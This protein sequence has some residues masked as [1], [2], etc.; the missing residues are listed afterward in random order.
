MTCCMAARMAQY[1]NDK[2]GHVSAPS[3][4]DKRQKA[5]AVQ[6]A[7]VHSEQ[8][9]DIIH[10]RMQTHRSSEVLESRQFS[11]RKGDAVCGQDGTNSRAI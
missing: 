1:Y 3:T 4:P 5:T 6:R 8:T 11:D 10:R 9:S 2:R 7:V